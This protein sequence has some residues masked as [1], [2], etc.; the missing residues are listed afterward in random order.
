MGA[1]AGLKFWGGQAARVR[2]RLLVLYKSQVSDPQTS[3][4]QL[5][6]MVKTDLR[7]L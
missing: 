1:I 3:D 7:M 5:T 2:P 4:D 6:G